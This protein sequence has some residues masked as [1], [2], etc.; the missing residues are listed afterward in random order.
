MPSRPCSTSSLRLCSQEA[1]WTIDM[2]VS[3]LKSRNN[4]FEKYARQIG[5]FQGSRVKKKTHLKPPPSLHGI[6]ILLL[7]P[8]LPNTLLL[9]V[10]LDPQIIPFY[11]HRSPQE[12]FAWKTRVFPSYHQDSTSRHLVSNSL[13]RSR[14]SVPCEFGGLVGWM[15]TVRSLMKTT[16][17]KQQQQQH[18][19]LIVDS[20]LETKKCHPVIW[21]NIFND[22]IERITIT[23]NIT[24]Q[25]PTKKFKILVKK[26]N[27][28][29]ILLEFIAINL[30][31]SVFLRRETSYHLWAVS[32]NC[33]IAT[34]DISEAASPDRNFTWEIW[35]QPLKK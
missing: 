15:V 29:W 31:G 23:I 9:E 3:L 4:P 10:W 22:D 19:D 7:H 30:D 6:C 32:S 26:I 5:S 13:S 11:K 2:M 21:F 27:P 12:G 18:L 35:I 1:C 16:N 17:S 28:W 20:W 8:R 34:G 33:Q 25:N 14:R 24:I